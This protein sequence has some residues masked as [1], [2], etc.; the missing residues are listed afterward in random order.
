MKLLSIAAALAVGLLLASCS[1]LKPD[2]TVRE[3]YDTVHAGDIAKL[4]SMASPEILTPG[5]DAQVAQLHAL[6]PKEPPTRVQ[7]IGRTMSTMT[8]AGDTLQDQELFEF[9]ARKA[10]VSALLHRANGTS[11]WK[12]KVF[13][14]KFFTP[15]ELQANAFTFRGKT[16]LHFAFLLATIASPIAMIAALVKVI[17]RKGLRRKWLWGLLSFVGLFSFA[18]NWSTGAV[19]INWL[20][21]QIIGAGFVSAA[22]GLAPWMLTFTLP[23]GAL[24]ILFGVWANP[25]RARD[26]TAAKKADAAAFD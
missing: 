18:M 13:N 8:N 17:R 2:P 12:V 6:L 26:K 15:A 14:V 11:P 23:V 5:F 22:P 16:A 9:G 25:A 4:R 19:S 21:V 20:T 1:M 24:L 7:V 10:V 3:I